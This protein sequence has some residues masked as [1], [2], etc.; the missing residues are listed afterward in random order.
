MGAA[1]VS[2]VF[3]KTGYHYD[4]LGFFYDNS[5][6]YRK[7]NSVKLS[8]GK[9]NSEG[10]E[11]IES[12]KS[13]EFVFELFFKENYDFVFTGGL[14]G[15]FRWFL[16]ILPQM[17]SLRPDC[18]FVI[19]GG[20]T[21]D[22]GENVLFEKLKVDFIL[23]GEAETN[24]HIF[25]NT[26]LNK[27]FKYS[28]LYEIPGI[29]WKNNAAALK[30]ITT[31]RFDLSSN[32]V[33]PLWESLPI[34]EY[35]QRSV[36]LFDGGKTFFP[37]MVG[38]GCPNVCAFCSPSIGKF[39]ASPAA[40]VIDEMHFWS[41][42]YSF[43]YFFLYS[44]VAF[45]NEKY[46]LEF[47]ELYSKTLSIPWACQLRPDI[48]FE[49]ETYSKMKKAGCERLYYGFESGNDR[50]LN[51]MKKH[52]TIADHVRN[53]ERARAAGL[54][55][56][57]SFVLGHAT[58]TA[59]EINE[60]LEFVD[61]YDLAENPKCGVAALLIYPGTGYYSLAE[62][63]GLV[64]DPF[65]FISSYSMKVSISSDTVREN[66][67]LRLN[68]TTMNNDS[69]F[70]TVCKKNIW[71]VRRFIDRHKAKDVETAF[72]RGLTPGFIYEGK[73]STCGK[74]L[75]FNN[76]SQPNALDISIKCPE[77]MYS[78]HIDFFSEHH[79]L[80]ELE[81]LNENFDRFDQ[82]VFF[83]SDPM[84]VIFNPALSFPVDK[85]VGWIDPS[86]PSVSRR[87]YLY[88]IKL[89]KINDL[90]LGCCLFL[91]N[92]SRK[93]TKKFFLDLDVCFNQENIVYIFPEKFNQHILPELEDKT[94]QFYGTSPEM[95]S[96]FYYLAEH[97]KCKDIKWQ[98]KIDLKNSYDFVIIDSSDRQDDRY[99][100]SQQTAYRIEQILYPS[101]FLELGCFAKNPFDKKAEIVR[102]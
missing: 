34:Q 98:E 38:R 80:A 29:C 67:N 33:L 37:I 54:R 11:F 99:V 97:G 89:K 16:S 68:I 77:C 20:I 47:C 72:D 100:L 35:I 24:L 27:N 30:K 71:R 82:I 83:G 28:D 36:S 9:C 51:V 46:A 84:S 25:L 75:N 102:F 23:K 91:S 59:E 65:R 17:K 22:L 60:T 1:Y 53:I 48:Q 52:S 31:Q 10:F 79:L 56:F 88:H 8:V 40:H 66:E 58:E 15:F 49:T 57:G 70:K 4:M 14:V 92:Q 19:G 73:C 2:A 94:V 3:E 6:W 63:M 44:E 96:V 62:K 32:H 45:D 101:F 12:S 42:K 26:I 85:L 50:I 13:M 7:Y 86:N 18:L 39:N 74:L 76:F 5:A 55:V 61:Q 21:K 41:E 78:S 64:D 43:D 95:N 69:F 87:N 81:I 90:D 93:V